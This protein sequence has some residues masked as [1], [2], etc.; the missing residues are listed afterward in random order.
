M[1]ASHLAA[2]CTDLTGP[3]SVQILEQQ[4]MPL[5]SGEVR[6]RVHA[7]GL[8][9]PD[10]LMTQGK[11]QFRPDPPFVP[12][13]EAAGEVIDVAPDVESFRPGDRVMAGN[14]GG[15]LAEQW[16]V[17]ASAASLLPAALSFS[18]GACWQTAGSTA[19]HALV[20]R[21]HLQS[22]ESVLILGASGG[23]GMAAVKMAKHIGATVI[24]TGSNEEK[25]QAIHQA[26]ADHLLD[27]SDED[28]AAKVKAFTDGKGVDVVFDPVGGD[29]ALTATRAIAWNGRYLIVGFASGTIPSF[30]ANH[31]MIK[32]YSLIGVRAGESPRRDPALAERQGA[33][34]RQLAAQGAMRPHISHRFPLSATAEA[35]RVL[36]RREAIGRVVVE[37]D[38]NA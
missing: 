2:V 3:S 35:L 1:T 6:I 17:K 27:P 28:L 38:P 18:E 29:L 4:S 34:L 9:F 33:A 20:E 37:I 5:Q 13:M 31:A 19:W 12:G 10:L 11:Y 14:K 30:P 21:G 25:L 32:T 15:A 23:V 26:G 8:N 16:V 36:E 24:G 22:G 7:A